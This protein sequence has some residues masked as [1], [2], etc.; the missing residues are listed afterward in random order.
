DHVGGD[1]DGLGGVHQ[2]ALDRLLDPVTGVGAEPGVHRGVEALDGPQQAQVALLDQ[3]LEGE[4][5]AG[6]AARDV[7]HPP[8]VGTHHAVAG[9]AVA[10]LDPVR[11]RLFLVRVEQGRLVDLAEVGFQGRLDRIAPE[12]ARSCHRESSSA[13]KGS[14]PL[15]LS[16]AYYWKGGM[17]N[18]TGN[19][20][21]GFSPP[22]RPVARAMGVSS[23]NWST[24]G[25]P[26]RKLTPPQLGGRGVEGLYRTKG[27]EG[28]RRAPEKARGAGNR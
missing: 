3:G 21:R 14:G 23:S 16:K 6:V 24:V 11:Q 8:Q 2:G 15:V 18:R 12:P 13:K 25:S 1:A 4:P 10:V 9:L 5:F 22:A 19:P 20:H 27:A 17:P 26:A 7:H 28:A